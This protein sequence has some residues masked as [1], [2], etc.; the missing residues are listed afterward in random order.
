MIEITAKNCDLILD[1][2]APNFVPINDFSRVI[3]VI[4]S[5]FPYLDMWR[6]FSILGTSFP[7]TMGVI[8]GGL[9]ILPRFE[10]QLY[11]KIVTNFT[12]DGLRLPVFGDYAIC[13]PKIVK[14]DMRVIHPSATVRYTIGNN[15]CIVK[16]KSN[17]KDPY[18]FKGLCQTLIDSGN[19][20]VPRISYG[21]EYIINCANDPKKKESLTT[22]RKVG[23]NHHIERVV[24]DVSS[25]CV[26]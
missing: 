26:A 11:K 15:W 18:Q 24:R 22:W 23:T 16:G 2:G 1:L 25:Y 8:K 21:D 13:H 12:R 3:Q 14:M 10:W 19:F 9:E 20:S 17:R 5:K 7:E 6:S 4:I